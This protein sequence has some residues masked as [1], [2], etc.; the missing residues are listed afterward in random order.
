[1]LERLIQAEKILRAV[2]EMQPATRASAEF[3]EVLNHLLDLIAQAVD[4]LQKEE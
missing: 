2:L 4:E 1:M 3:S